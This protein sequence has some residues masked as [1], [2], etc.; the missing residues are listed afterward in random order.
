MTSI[1]TTEAEGITA[2]I[3]LQPISKPQQNKH[4]EYESEVRHNLYWFYIVK[5]LLTH[6]DVVDSHDGYGERRNEKQENKPQN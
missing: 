4:L 5:A 2:L 6:H 3:A 1:G